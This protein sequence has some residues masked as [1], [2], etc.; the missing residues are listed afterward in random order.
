MSLKIDLEPGMTL[1][2][3]DA[4]V[5][6]VAKTGRRARLEITADREKVPVKIQNSKNAARP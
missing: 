2:I 1:T 4:T 5:K 6:L 3:G